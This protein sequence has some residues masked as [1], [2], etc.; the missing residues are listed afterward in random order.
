MEADR[1]EGVDFGQGYFPDAVS[2]RAAKHL[3]EL[4]Y[5]VNQGDRA[6]LLF[7]V[8]HSGINLV[9][10]AD[11]IDKQYGLLLREVVRQGVEV[12]AYSG[13]ISPEELVLE[14]AIPVRF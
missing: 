12:Y 8:Q 4:L 9:S 10:P 6:V 1:D 7:C 11:H 3:R 13:K 2:K 14:K 5:M